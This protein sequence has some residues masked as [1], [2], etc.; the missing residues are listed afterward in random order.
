VPA[1][2]FEHSE[3]PEH[4]DVRVEVGTL[5]RHAHVGLRR[6]MKADVRPRLVEDRVRIPPDVGLVH[7]HALWNVLAL[8][9]RKVVEDVHL[10]L[11]RE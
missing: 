10:V 7:P 4:V 8:P 2:G 5:H 11:A 1:R 6:E 9:M 3:R